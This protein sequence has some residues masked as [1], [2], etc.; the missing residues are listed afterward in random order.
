[1]GG[2]PVAHHRPAGTTGR[3]L[4]TGK[5]RVG[6]DSRP[7]TILINTC[8]I[9]RVRDRDRPEL[10]VASL[11]N[12][13]SLPS[14]DA[15]TWHV[16]ASLDPGR[17]NAFAECLH[18]ERVMGRCLRVCRFRLGTGEECA[19]EV[20]GVVRDTAA[21]CVR[22]WRQRGKIAEPDVRVFPIAAG[23]RG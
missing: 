12:G 16:S 11:R 1:M 2:P 13:F 7:I 21:K 3:G 10:S 8:Q 15:S 9:R 4:L 23:Y 6:H 17:A 5:Q 14:S 18:L 19:A 22:W 20:V